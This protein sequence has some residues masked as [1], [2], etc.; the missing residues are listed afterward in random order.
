MRQAKAQVASHSSCAHPNLF[1]LE[2]TLL[3]VLPELVALQPVIA[4]EAWRLL[5]S[6]QKLLHRG[7]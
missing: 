1:I 2:A 7:D 3:V 6:V 4:D 5:I